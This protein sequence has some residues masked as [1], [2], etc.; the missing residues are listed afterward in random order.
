MVEQPKSGMGSHTEA[1][2]RDRTFLGRVSVGTRTTIFFLIGIAVFI[3]GTFALLFADKQINEANLNLNKSVELASHISSIER[4][5]WRIRAE[6]E[7]LSKLLANSKFAFSDAGKAASKEHVTLANTLGLRLDELYQKTNAEIISKQVSTLRE[8]VALY[9]EQ[10]KKS[11]K[12]KADP[13]PDMTGLEAVVRQAI[14]NISKKLNKVNILSLNETMAEI[15]AVTTEFIESG[16]SRDLATIENAEKEFIRLLS[17]VPISTEDKEAFKS[18]ILKYQSA[19]SAYAKYRLVHDNTR[20]RLDEI[21]S[22][23]VPSI[24]A[25]TSFSANNLAQAQFQEQKVRKKYRKLIAGGIAGAF[26]FILLIG[27]IIQNS[28]SSPIITAARAARNLYSGKL[29]FKVRG[30]GNTDETGDIARALVS[31]KERL[32]DAN[33]LQKN[34]KIAK[35]EAER[36]RAA[37][38]EAEWL[39]KDLESMKAEADKGKLA[40]TEVALLRKILEATTDSVKIKKIEVDKVRDEATE[41]NIKT[42]TNNRAVD[43]TSLDKISTI[44]RQ[45]ARSSEH[46]TAAAEEA[47]RT[48]TLIRSLS[49]ASEKINT[50][51]SLI[52]TIGEQA[53]MPV[54]NTPEQN[55]EPNLVVLNSLTEN[56]NGIARRFDIIR[57]S[58]NQATWA[59]RDI[60]A[61]ITKSRE[62]ALEI[63]R[64]SSADALEV[65]TDLLQQSEN[66]RA[67]LDSL[68]SKMQGQVTDDKVIDIE[69]NEEENSV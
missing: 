29:D 9:M 48:G 50:V 35:T 51:E 49:D 4:D 58:S 47:E 39:R 33:K 25:I 61:I 40:I 26:T 53:D 10:Y 2:Y 17:A 8:A 41:N 1:R 11:T 30:L 22:Y 65:T 18:D 20:D 14:R 55:S 12:V 43:D 6:S 13:I 19:M 36:G 15:R 27:I 44:S 46:V 21:V 45:V 38:A 23:M 3:S 56:S 42:T 64:L 16:A 60:A 54:I 7:E 34:M 63:A 67:M 66:L 68:V 52:T 5:V 24:D 69:K 37:S 57:S 62:V 32:S 59:I 28:I 31:I